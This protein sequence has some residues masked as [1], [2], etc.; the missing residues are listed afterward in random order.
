MFH[1]NN[2]YLDAYAK[3]KTKIK[4]EYNLSGGSVMTTENAVEWDRV[5]LLLN[6][7]APLS[8]VQ[9]ELGLIPENWRDFIYGEK[10]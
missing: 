5:R 10:K 7:T 9:M 2:K 8:Q 1:H 6:P 4:N 3:L